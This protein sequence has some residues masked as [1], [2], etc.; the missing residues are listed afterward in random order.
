M[1]NP[2]ISQIHCLTI[3]FRNNKIAMYLEFW[4]FQNEIVESDRPRL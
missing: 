2:V 3:L 4:I 1:P